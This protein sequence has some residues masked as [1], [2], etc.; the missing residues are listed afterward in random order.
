M[1][2]DHARDPRVVSLEMVDGLLLGH[3][4]ENGDEITSVRRELGLEHGKP[5]LPAQCLERRPIEVVEVR[6]MKSMCRRQTARFDV[7][8]LYEEPP[9]FGEP[10]SER[11]E[12][13]R[14]IFD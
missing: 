4:S 5:R 9:V 3:P 2:A 13:P 12:N 10:G 6:E 1:A 11:L 8:H 7:R 14:R